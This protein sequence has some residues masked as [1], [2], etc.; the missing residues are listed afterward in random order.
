MKDK[1]RET[2]AS[3]SGV[4]GLRL[5]CRCWRPLGRES[6]AVLVFVHGLAE[7]SGRYQFPVNHF[8]PR[9]FTIYA[10][11]L[12]GH[13]HSEGRRGY[14]ESIDHLLGDIRSFLSFVKEREPKRKVFLVGHSFGGQ[15][16]LNYGALF[17]D[18]LSG[19]VVSSPN[20]ELALKVALW[21]RLA[22][23]VLSHLAPT[24]K[25][26][27]DISPSLISRDRRV[28]EAYKRDERVQRRITARL[29]DIVLANRLRIMD[30]AGRFKVPCLLM[31]AGDDR[32]CAPE[33]TRGFFQKIPIRDKTLKIYDG[34][35][36]EL[37][38]EPG[39]ENVFRDMEEWIEAR[40]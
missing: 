4:E 14:A 26:P 36:H 15:L 3:F 30:L 37:F 5:F 18:S 32:I 35:Y 34:F 8:V 9:G 13:G 38:N 19:I 31:H 16:V 2:T 39:K 1:I 23:P 20:I 29:G 28:V 33:G 10:M 21:K 22:A 25:L 11:D 17:P 40:I 24:L 27:N 12:R 7:H 6:R